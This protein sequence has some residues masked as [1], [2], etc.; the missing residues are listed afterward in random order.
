MG[1]T[2]SFLPRSYTERLKNF[3]MISLQERMDFISM[4][5]LFELLRKKLDC[6]SLLTSFN[7]RA[8]V[9]IPRKPITP[10]Y[11]WLTQQN[12]TWV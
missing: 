1:F 12:S 10:L 9:R 2:H 3:E 4:G 6:P 11:S 8:P 7:F 5:F